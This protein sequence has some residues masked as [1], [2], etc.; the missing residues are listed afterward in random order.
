MTQNIYCLYVKI[1]DTENDSEKNIKLI[2]FLYIKLKVFFKTLK[3]N[4][5]L[6]ITIED[7]ND[8]IETSDIFNYL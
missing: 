2:H 1:S 7:E 3:E 4:N 8:L 6:S 5:L